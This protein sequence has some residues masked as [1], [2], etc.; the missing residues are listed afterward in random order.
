MAFSDRDRRI[1][2]TTDWEI[3]QRA[4]NRASQLLDRCPKTHERCNDL[5]RIIMAIFESG[6]RDED[7]LAVMAANRELNFLAGRGHFQKPFPFRDARISLSEPRT[8]H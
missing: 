3:M 7:E 2:A 1:F 6:I 8:E 4:H 5:A